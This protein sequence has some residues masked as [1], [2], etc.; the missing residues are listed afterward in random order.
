MEKK[1]VFFC[2]ST[3]VPPNSF[4]ISFHVIIKETVD[5]YTGRFIRQLKLLLRSEKLEL[6]GFKGSTK[7]II[8]KNI[9]RYPDFD[10]DIPF[11][12][13]PPPASVTPYFLSILSFP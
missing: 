12:F 6:I 3:L 2:H 4:C 9:E 7:R 10:W 5:R 1:V 11:P 13:A 8:T